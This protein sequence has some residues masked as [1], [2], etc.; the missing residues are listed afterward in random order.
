MPM[1]YNKLRVR[2]T[3]TAGAVFGFVVATACAKEKPVPQSSGG[4][5]DAAALGV[6]TVTAAAG[7]GVH[8]TAGDTK[9][10]RKA[11]EYEL[12]NDNFASFL[13]AADSLQA[14]QARDTAVRALLVV[15]DSTDLPTKE[16]DAGVRLLE[17]NPVVNSAI[18]SAGISPR[19][20][21]VA[22][23]AIAS[24]ERFI[25]N[26]KAA[27]PTPTLQKNAEFLRAKTAD[28]EHL[29]ALRQ[30]MT[31]VKISP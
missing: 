7:P 24:A 10:V 30:G 26:P 23:I 31:V 22:S 16:E 5:V 12:T 13:R 15:R 14:L 1:H 21:F 11:G 27:P 25:A 9:S 29:R 2:R 19:D 8:V 3:M 4:A 18:T 6:G 20:Y 17:S 28:L